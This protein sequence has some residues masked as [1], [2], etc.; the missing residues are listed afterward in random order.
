MDT[1]YYWS[2][3][4]D[5]SGLISM[6]GVITVVPAQPQTLTVKVTSGTFN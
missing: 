2:S 3:F 5:S 1:Y 4:I 6:R